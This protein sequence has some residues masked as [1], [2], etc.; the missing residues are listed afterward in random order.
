MA[1][2]LF[3]FSTISA[4]MEGKYSENQTPQPPSNS[5]IEQFFDLARLDENAFAYN[6]GFEPDTNVF[7][8]NIWGYHLQG[9]DNQFAPQNEGVCQQHLQSDYFH[10]PQEGN[11][12]AIRPFGNYHN[13]SEAAFDTDTLAKGE[14]AAQ[15]DED[16]SDKDA[17]GEDDSGYEDCAEGGTEHGGRLEEEVENADKAEEEAED[18]EDSKQDDEY[19]G[20]TEHETPTF[21]DKIF[22]GMKPKKR[23]GLYFDS[24]EEG[25]KLVQTVRWKPPQGMKA[26]PSTE[27][28]KA[29]YVRKICGA[30]LNTITAKD[31]KSQKFGKR[32]VQPDFYDPPAVEMAARIILERL[33]ALHDVGYQIVMNDHTQLL[34]PYA[35]KT[36]TFE[37]RMNAEWKSA[38]VNV[39]KGVSIDAY[40]AGPNK[41]IARIESNGV[42]NKHKAELLRKGREAAKAT[43]TALK[44]GREKVGKNDVA[45]GD[46][47]APKRRRRPRVIKEAI[48]SEDSKEEGYL[49]RSKGKKQVKEEATSPVIAPLRRS[50]RVKK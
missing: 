3:T 30:L 29:H 17:E 34:C 37:E 10:W 23:T 4:S 39:L 45:D 44:R 25:M 5:E 22:A 13:Y 28:E 48:P 12:Q 42:G 40:V 14:D 21:K 8:H 1:S 50:Q 47:P 2:S 18:A 7:I 33:I 43:K 26:L 9:R 32:W 49:P 16:N 20:D 15:G 46:A 11:L 36:L 6:G 38:C 24:Y 31:A 27:A 19:K 41:A 35:D